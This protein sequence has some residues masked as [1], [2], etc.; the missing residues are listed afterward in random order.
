VR[1][2][3]NAADVLNVEGGRAEGDDDR[4][5]LLGAAHRPLGAD[6]DG[7]QLTGMQSKLR[8]EVT[9]VMGHKNDTTTFI[10]LFSFQV[11]A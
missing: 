1:W 5:P 4:R 2:K 10:R 9:L 11:P 3:A 8:A 6:G 7:A